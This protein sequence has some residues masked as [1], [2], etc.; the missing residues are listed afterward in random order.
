MLLWLKN[1]QR[2]N[3]PREAARIAC[4]LGDRALNEGDLPGARAW[5]ERARA[6]DPQ[7]EMAD[8]RIRHLE[9]PAEPV[10]VPDADTS[11]AIMAAAGRTAQGSLT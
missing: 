1:C 3:D 4:E 7:N 5:F 9:K 10:V 6:Y 11:P 8:R 2:R